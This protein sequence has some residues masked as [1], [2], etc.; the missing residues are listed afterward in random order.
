MYSHNLQ[1]ADVDRAV[2]ALVAAG[3]DVARAVRTHHRDSAL[4][5]PRQARRIEPR[6]RLHRV[7]R[8]LALAPARAPV[9]NQ[10]HVALLDMYLMVLFG[11][12]EILGKDT[13][14]GLHPFDLFDLRYV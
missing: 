4:M 7:P 13:V 2:E 3:N 5:Q 8:T 11:G 1:R 10:Q 12:V 9:A 6:H 14:A